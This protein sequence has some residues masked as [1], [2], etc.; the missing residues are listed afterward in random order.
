[1]EKTGHNHLKTA[2]VALATA[3]ALSSGHGRRIEATRLVLDDTQAAHTAPDGSHAMST[4]ES[5]ISDIIKKQKTISAQAGSGSLDSEPTFNW[6]TAGEIG[7]IPNFKNIKIP[8]ATIAILKSEVDAIV[9]HVKVEIAKAKAEGKPP[10]IHILEVHDDK[11]ALA[12]ELAVLLRLKNELG[13]TNIHVELPQAQYE[14]SKGAS[15]IYANIATMGSVNPSESTA[16][17]R[18][19]RSKLQKKVTGFVDDTYNM[20]LITDVASNTGMKITFTQYPPDA[21]TQKDVLEMNNEKF[22]VNINETDRLLVDQIKNSEKT[23]KILFTGG[24]HGKAI[25][26]AGETIGYH[27]I[28]ITVSAP[29]KRESMEDPWELRLKL[30]KELGK[31]FTPQDILAKEFFDKLHFE[32]ES[33]FQARR[34]VNVFTLGEST[35][36]V[37]QLLGD[38]ARE[39]IPSDWTILGAFTPAQ[40]RER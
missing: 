8:P 2:V 32:N 38:A 18:L 7:K 30:L 26:E 22:W 14:D 20:V 17:E 9:D 34:E 23:A 24:L 27:V 21:K 10:L 15:K 19:A 5:R 25:A 3:V 6:G 31:P 40:V 1:M 33:A 36:A 35:R 11:N 16:E 12:K 37:E 13:I 29:I 39:A 4:L 28:P